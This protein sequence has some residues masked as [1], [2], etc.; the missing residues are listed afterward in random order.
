MILRGEVKVNGVKITELGTK[1]LFGDLVTIKD[2]VVT[3]EHKVYVLL[4]KPK[5]CVTTMS[6]PEGRLTV[7]DLIR[8]AC[9][10]RIFPVG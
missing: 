9:P 8:K 4:N 5:N 7:M 10:E 2:K 1:I 6:D 3:P